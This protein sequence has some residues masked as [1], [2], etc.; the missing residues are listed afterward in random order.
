M[1]K[2]HRGFT[3]KIRKGTNTS[4]SYATLLDGPYGGSQS[5]YAQFHSVLLCAGS[6]GVSFTRS[7]LQDLA[8]R[9]RLPLP[10][11]RL[12]FV[13]C[14]KDVSWASWFDAEIAAAIDKLDKTGID[15]QVS[16]FVTR[17]TDLSVDDTDSVASFADNKL[18]LEKTVAVDGMGQRLRI[19][20]GRP[21]VRSLLAELLDGAEGES[22]VGVCGPMTLTSTLRQQVVITSDER[23]VHKGGL[24][25]GCYLHVESTY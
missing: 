6:T 13:W 7:I 21:D 19:M 10:L 18:P 16:L 12:H 24:P 17:A 23:A 2:S 1:L 11:R 20:P 8:E 3:K 5:D 4:T 14:I 9:S 22:G 25:Q 15:A